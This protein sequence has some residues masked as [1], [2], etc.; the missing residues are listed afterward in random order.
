MG[1][2]GAIDNVFDHV[3]GLGLDAGA[4]ECPVPPTLIAPF[5]NVG[6]VILRCVASRVIPQGDKTVFFQYGPAPQG[7]NRS[8]GNVGGVWN[9]HTASVRCKG[10]AVKGA[11]DV[12]SRDP[13]FATGQVGA[14]VGAVGV[15]NSDPAGFAAIGDEVLIEVVQWFYLTDRELLRKQGDVPAAGIPPGL[16]VGVGVFTHAGHSLWNFFRRHVAPQYRQRSWRS[17]WWPRRPGRCRP[18]PR[19]WHC[20]RRT[21]HR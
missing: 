11:G 20:R 14:Q 10:P 4:I 12:I 6:Q 18:S 8:V 16:K 15:K 19:H 7:I 2:M 17:R 3:A 13:S 5:G 21:G 9:V 1:E